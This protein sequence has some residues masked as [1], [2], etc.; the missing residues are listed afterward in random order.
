MLLTAAVLERKEG[1]YHSTSLA[2]FSRQYSEKGEI[3]VSGRVTQAL[4]CTSLLRQRL[5]KLISTAKWHLGK[6]EPVNKWELVGLFTV[7]IHTDTY[8]FKAVMR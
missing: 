8:K 6:V 7:H 1:H 2:F 3:K 5:G 4:Q